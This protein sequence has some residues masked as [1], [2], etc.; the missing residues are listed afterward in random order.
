MGKVTIANINGMPQTIEGRVVYIGRLGQARLGNPFLIGRDGT[1]DEVI[2][3]HDR[4]WRGQPKIVEALN[5]LAAEK[6]DVW[7]LCHCAPQP[8]HGDNYKR[9]I[10]RLRGE[11]K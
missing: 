7:L 9:E 1:R 2:A 10:E 6:R 8:C 4:W 5:D 11:Q 3:R